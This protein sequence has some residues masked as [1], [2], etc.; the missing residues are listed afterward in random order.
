M[1]DIDMSKIKPYD[2]SVY[3]YETDRMQIVHHSNYI[4]WIEEARLDWMTQIG[5]DYKSVEDHLL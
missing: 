2:R 5:W 3:Y 4:R 1:I